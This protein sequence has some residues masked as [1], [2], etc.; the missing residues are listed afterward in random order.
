MEINWDLYK[1]HLRKAYFNFPSRECEN[2]ISKG[3]SQSEDFWK[4]FDKYLKVMAAKNAKLQNKSKDPNERGPSTSAVLNEV[5]LP[6]KFS[7]FDSQIHNLNLEKARRHH[8]KMYDVPDNVQKEFEYIIDCYLKFLQR[9]KMIKLKKLR[10]SQKNLPICQHKK[11]ILYAVRNNPVTII[12]GDTGCG[13]STQVPQY[14]LNDGFENICCT[15]PR[16]IACISLAKRVAFETLNEYGSEIAYQIRFEKTKTKA[17]K[18]LFLTEG[19]LLR[20]LSSDPDLN[21]YSVII[22]DEIHERHLHGDFLLGILKRLIQRRSSDLKLILMSATINIDLFAHYFS[23]LSKPPIINV[24]GRLYPIQLEYHALAGRSSDRVDDEKHKSFEKS[25]TEKVD[26]APFLRIVRMIDEKFPKTERGDLLMFLSGITEMTTVA[27]VLKEYADHTKRWLILLLHSTLSIQ[28]QDRVFDV[29]PE[30]VRK[31]ILS[32][33]IAETSVTIDGVR[34]VVDSGKVKEMR[35]DSE[36]KT[37]KLTEI[38]V[39]KASAEQRKGRAGRTGPGVCYRLY[40]EQ[41]YQAFEQYSLPEIRRVSL[42]S[43]VLQMYY[44]GLSDPLKFDFIESP[45]LSSIESAMEYLINQNALTKDAQ[46]LTPTGQM[47][48]NLPVD[49]GVGKMLLLGCLFEQC[50]V[51]LTT[52]AALSIQQIFTQRSF[53]DLDCQTSRKN[54]LSDFG[55]PFTLINTYREWMAV[56]LDGSE[57]SSRWCRKRGVEEQRLYEITK[58]RNQFKEILQDA[59][60]I[61]RRE[62]ELT[63][64]ERR[65]RRGEIDQLKKLRKEGQRDQ[66]KRKILKMRHFDAALQD[67]DEEARSHGEGPSSK[68]YS[69]DVNSLEFEIRHTKGLMNEQYRRILDSGN[70]YKMGTDL[71]LHSKFKPFVI[72]HPN[73][74][75]ADDPEVLCNTR[76]DKSGSKSANHQLL[77]YALLLETTKP[78]LVNVT[79]VPALHTLLLVSTNLDTSADF[80]RIICDRFIEFQIEDSHVAENIISTVAEIRL[81]LSQCLERKLNGDKYRNS[82]LFRKLQLFFQTEVWYSMKRLLKADLDDINVHKTGIFS[83][84]ADFLNLSSIKSTVPGDKATEFVATKFTCDGCAKEFYFTLPDRLEHLK[85]CQL[86]RNDEKFG[87]LEQGEKQ[88]AGN[89]SLKRAYRCE[90]CHEDLFSTPT[91]ILKHKISHKNIILVRG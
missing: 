79:R 75:L 57:S 78:Y 43:L 12:A 62:L 7:K 19:L 28:E 91:E 2:I 40:S 17:T 50:D 88:S 54:L 51:I 11:E 14:L 23:D 73:G 87:D 4:F 90:I 34:F 41:Q 1:A 69:K 76:Y 66:R 20:Q 9:E 60:L 33:N 26:P 37:H 72:L 61:E 6:S 53:R 39:S 77:F 89:V 8:L 58:L 16:R 18:M 49:I 36:T 10:I 86:R 74:S 68:K 65:I 31:C 25:K 47:L 48:V 3:T 44:L 52:A 27:E 38:W 81:L 82:E 71:I 64:V 45:E 83:N 63:S 80:R 24:P 56:K 67:S 55:D 70:S 85:G 32:T 22:L 29:A 35:H 42:E 21:N 59:D 13:K 30:G 5:G 15:Q 46:S 84:Q